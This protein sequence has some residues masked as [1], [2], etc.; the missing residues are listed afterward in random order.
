MKLFWYHCLYGLI[1]F[2][3]LDYFP[4][5]VVV[6][7]VLTIT[8]LLGTFPTEL[9]FPSGI[10]NSSIVNRPGATGS[11]S[12]PSTALE[13]VCSV[14]FSLLVLPQ[15]NIT[16]PLWSDC[17]VSTSGLLSVTKHRNSSSMTS[18]SSSL[19]GRRETSKDIFCV[20]AVRRSALKL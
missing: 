13:M 9:V 14:Q 12:A 6:K 7:K 20:V 16:T 19:L 10:L 5:S 1:Y 2:L 11:A 15:K 17:A 3:L 8:R 18:C 4:V